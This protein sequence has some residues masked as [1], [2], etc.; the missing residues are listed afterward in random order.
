M[1]AP[2]MDEPVIAMLKP[3]AQ[4]RGL[5]NE[6]LAAVRDAGFQESLR[7]VVQLDEARVRRLFLHP[8]PA[9]VQHL[10]SRP[11]SLH[12]LQG[13]GGAEAFYD[14][15]CAIRRH[16][17]VPSKVRNLIH[18]TDEGTEY[19]LFLDAFF[20]ELAP[21][22][23]SAGAD[24][25]LR[26][27]AETTLQQALD[28]LRQLDEDSQFRHVSVSLTPAQA[29]LCALQRRDWKRLRLGFAALHALPASAGG[30]GRLLLHAR[31]QEDV[32]PLLA[33]SDPKALLA[34]MADPGRAVTLTDIDIPASELAAYANELRKPA[35]EVDRVL[36][37]YPCLRWVAQ[38]QLQGVSRLGVFQ[39]RQPLMAAE[40]LSDIARLLGLQACGGSA[41]RCAVGAF[42]ISGRRAQGLHGQDGSSITTP[43]M[44]PPAVPARHSEASA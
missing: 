18:G 21:R 15:K 36:W 40:F 12:L 19:H 32:R 23:Y 3:D 5:A 2:A 1:Q 42:S 28:C 43:P 6:V 38:L 22:Q 16:F 29:D 4:E 34:D 13:G 41:G 10:C 37:A 33:L 27:P 30:V 35:P 9:Y 17:G 11:V 26:W 14:C 44:T 24:L 39:P 25:D 31:A 8:L 20:P 7:R